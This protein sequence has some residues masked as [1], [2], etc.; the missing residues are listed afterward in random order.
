MNLYWIAY[1]TIGLAVGL[2]VGYL[3]GQ[4]QGY[5]EGWDCCAEVQRTAHQIRGQKAAATRKRKVVE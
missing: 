2:I 1:V 4:K 5:N 3:Q